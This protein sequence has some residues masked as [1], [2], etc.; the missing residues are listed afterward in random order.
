MH[1]HK[2]YVR[3]KWLALGVICLWA[4]MTVATLPATAEVVLRFDPAFLNIEPG[5]DTTL[6][7]WMDDPID[8]RAFE[9]SIS[10]PPG[11]VESISGTPG[12]LFT[13][14]GYQIWEGFENDE[15]GHW[16]GF[17]IVMGGY[18]WLAGPGELFNWSFRGL[19]TG[20]ILIEVLD[21]ALYAPDATLIP[22]VILEQMIAVSTDNQT[23][24]NL[25]ALYR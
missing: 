1:Q 18:D 15:P 22:D 3:K 10:Y 19:N 20:S 8:I 2:T 4:L 7:I 14:S 9:V 16:H 21:V 17:A 25:K 24:G 5:M 12:S 23:W 11:L 13:D 6:S